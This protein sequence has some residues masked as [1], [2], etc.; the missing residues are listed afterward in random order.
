L[1]TTLSTDI[2]KIIDTLHTQALAGDAQAIRII[3]DRVLPALR[4][5]DMPTMLDLPAASLRTL[6]AQV[7]G[8][9]TA[10]TE[11]HRKDHAMIAN[12]ERQ[13]TGPSSGRAPEN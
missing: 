2:D 8:R 7:A 12:A 3:L 6:A 13:I 1:R 11:P 10:R 9:N 4:P 5:V